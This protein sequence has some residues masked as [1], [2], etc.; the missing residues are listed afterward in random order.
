M[1]IPIDI[2]TTIG[3]IKRCPLLITICAPN[4]A[5]IKPP[6]AII[7]PT[8]Q[9]GNPARIN[10]INAAILEVKFKILVRAVAST[11]PN[12]AITTKQIVKNE[13]VPGPKKP[14]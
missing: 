13:P 7:K 4:R 11:K 9:I 8:F 14:S 3:R 1:A 12:C 10:N 5:P 6:A 2:T